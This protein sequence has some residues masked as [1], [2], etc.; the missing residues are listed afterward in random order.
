L[1]KTIEEK[2][3]VL[4]DEEQDELR[5][6]W[7]P[8]IWVQDKEMYKVEKINYFRPIEQRLNEPNEP[9]RYQEYDKQLITGEVVYRDVKLE[10][11]MFYNTVLETLRAQVVLDEVKHVFPEEN[12][13]EEFALFRSL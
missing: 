4:K 2:L 10:V 12:Y 13:A 8:E 3:C 1:T 5:L 7:D 6:E 9:T 11:T